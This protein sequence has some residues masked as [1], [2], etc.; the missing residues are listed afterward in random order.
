MVAA[1]SAKFAR[2]KK[3]SVS[4]ASPMGVASS[5]KAEKKRKNPILIVYSSDLQQ[6]LCAS[7][8]LLYDETPLVESH[9]S[10]VAEILWSRE[11]EEVKTFYQNRALDM[12]KRKP[13]LDS[14]KVSK[15]KRKYKAPVSSTR[16]AQASTQA[17]TDQPGPGGFSGLTIVALADAI[18]TLVPEDAAGF[19][20]LRPSALADVIRP[21]LYEALNVAELPFV[22]VDDGLAFPTDSS[23]EEHFTAYTAYIGHEFPHD[24]A[25]EL[26]DDDG[27]AQTGHPNNQAQFDFSDHAPGPTNA[28]GRPE[29]DAPVVRYFNAGAGGLGN[30]ALAPSDMP[31]AHYDVLGS[32]ST[33]APA[34]SP[35][36]YALEALFGTLPP[37]NGATQE[38]IT[39]YAPGSL[40][41]GQ[42]LEETLCEIDYELLWAQFI[43]DL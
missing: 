16:A 21:M 20:G 37:S 10:Q 34:F 13:A 30:D 22:I 36:H 23:L 12:K 28:P 39:T 15:S 40:E 29:I 24:A 8:D 27:A 3:G 38:P 32:F 7:R 14:T 5:R 42:A 1:S 35:T 9:V 18:L 33:I 6:S 17:A 2:K 11:P 43:N 41:R 31:N 19:P 26:F 25:Q 4:G